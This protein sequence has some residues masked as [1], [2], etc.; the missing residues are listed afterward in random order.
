MIP[1]A[2]LKIPRIGVLVL[3]QQK[4]KILLGRRKGTLAPGTWGP[5][6]GHLEYGETVEACAQRELLEETGLVAKQCRLGPWV[7]CYFEGYKHYVTL[8]VFVD[9]FEGEPQLLEPEKCEGWQWFAWDN[10]PHPLL[11]S[12]ALYVQKQLPRVEEPSTN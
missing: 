7:E 12:L 1:S 11:D 9:E 8:I 10:L 4:G 5:P 6:G 3:L 2:D